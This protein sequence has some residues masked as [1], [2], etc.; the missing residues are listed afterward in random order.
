M[1]LKKSEVPLKVFERD[2]DA[3][4]VTVNLTVNVTVIVTVN[5]TVNV[6]VS[7]TVTSM[8]LSLSMSSKSY[9]YL[10]ILLINQTNSL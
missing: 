7:V 2:G 9:C 6:T 3:A 1:C 8:L 4:R 10:F 5:V